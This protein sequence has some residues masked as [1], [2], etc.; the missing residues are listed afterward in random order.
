M[1]YLLLISFAILIT[2]CTDSRSLHTNKMTLE[3][4]D[5]LLRNGDSME[6]RTMIIDD[7][8][9]KKMYTDIR[10]VRPD[11]FDNSFS[12]ELITKQVKLTPSVKRTL[13]FIQDS[14]AIYFNEV[15][16]MQYCL[17][18]IQ[19]NES[20]ENREL[21]KEDYPR[22]ISYIKE[23]NNQQLLSHR[24]VYWISTLMKHCDFIVENTLT[25][26]L[27]V[28]VLKEDYKTEFSGGVTY[29]FI[30]EKK[31]TIPFLSFTSWMR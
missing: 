21:A 14:F 23:K 26:K 30:S 29:Y 13:V 17:D 20:P 25:K 15:Q 27:P 6:V 19:K 8:T 1:K 18:E 24:S 28:A 7:S 31:D 22:L 12:V 4:I 9:I 3:K 10:K 5:T 2:Q 16:A 11:S